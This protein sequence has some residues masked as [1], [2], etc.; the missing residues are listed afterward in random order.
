M[1]SA[2]TLLIFMDDLVVCRIPITVGSEDATRAKYEA[3]PR[4]RAG[5]SGLLEKMFLMSTD[6]LNCLTKSRI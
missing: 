2:H 6:V 1:Q 4:S 5:L 3:I